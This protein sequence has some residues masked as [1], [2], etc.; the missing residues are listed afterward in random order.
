MSTFCKSSYLQSGARL[1][2]ICEVKEC[3][4]NVMG[5]TDSGEAEDF[6]VIVC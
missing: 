3:L 1:L 2:Y 4:V 6:I 5:T